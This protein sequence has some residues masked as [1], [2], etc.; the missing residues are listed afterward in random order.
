MKRKRIDIISKEP[1]NFEKINKDCE[2]LIKSEEGPLQKQRE[3]KM[4]RI[5]RE[6]QDW[7]TALLA[8]SKSREEA[9]ERRH[10]EALAE[11]KAAIDAYKE[12]MSKMIDKL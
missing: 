8:H 4:T 11:S 10:K 1:N 6:L 5:Q 12:M 7:S 3:R 9:R 2:S